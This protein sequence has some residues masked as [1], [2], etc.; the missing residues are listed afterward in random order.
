MTTLKASPSGKLNIHDR[1]VGKF[2]GSVPLNHISRLLDALVGRRWWVDPLVKLEAEL[3][4]GK[5]D[6]A[7]WHFVNKWRKKMKL[8]YKRNLKIIA[9][10]EKAGFGR[11]IYFCLIERGVYQERKYEADFTVADISASSDEDS[12]S[13]DKASSSSEDDIAGNNV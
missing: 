12:M 1:P 5:N 11:N 8:V 2:L 10:E 6:K 7:A 4:L 9:E 13:L 3:V